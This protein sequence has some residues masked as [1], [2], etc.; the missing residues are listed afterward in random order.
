MAAELG[1]LLVDRPPVGQAEHL[2][3]AAVGQDRPAPADELVQAAAPRDEL[4]ARA[5]EQVVGVAQNDRRPEVLEVLVQ[6]RLHAAL[7][8]HWHERRGLHHAVRRGHGAQARGA[9]DTAHGEGKGR[10]HPLLFSEA[11]LQ[12]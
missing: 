9:V 10:G 6:R 5:Q 12:H 11:A 1:A 7:R 2:E 3:A 8:A 4:V